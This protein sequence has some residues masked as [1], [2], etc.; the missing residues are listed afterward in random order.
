MDLALLAGR[1]DPEVRRACRRRITDPALAED[2]AQET[3]LRACAAVRRGAGPRT[4]ARAWLHEIARSACADAVAEQARAARRTAEV[5]EDLP[6]RGASP[7][8]LLAAREDLDVLARDLRALPGRDR[9]V[10]LEVAAG[11]RVA[12]R[13]AERARRRLRDRRRGRALRCADAR[14]RAVAGGA[15]G[16]AVAAHLEACPPCARAW[17]RRAAARL[18]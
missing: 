6:A 4:A 18:V 9:R 7:A 15:Q 12:P 14:R 13:D 3:W 16:T 10:L 11:R 17:R 8:E 5:P 1:Y 2:A